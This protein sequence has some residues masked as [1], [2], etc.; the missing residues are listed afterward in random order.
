MTIRTARHGALKNP[1][2]GSKKGT[3]SMHYRYLCAL[4][5]V[6][7]VSSTFEWWWK[8]KSVE[9]RRR[10]QLIRT[11]LRSADARAETAFPDA[12]VSQP[13][14]S[15]IPK[16]EETVPDPEYLSQS[17]I[18]C[19]SHHL[20]YGHQGGSV[21]LAQARPCL[22]STKDYFYQHGT[23]GYESRSSLESAF[24]PGTLEAVCV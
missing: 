10:L 11:P 24:I 15:H 14:S 13:T 20:G 1:S 3:S 21:L 17:Q 4:H 5:D 9:D 19:L 2:S 12:S 23:S 18:Y 7:T 8:G 6:P 16:H 22:A